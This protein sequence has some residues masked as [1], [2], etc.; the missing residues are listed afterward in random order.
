[1]PNHPRWT[2][3]VGL[4]SYSVHP[5]NSVEITTTITPK[6]QRKN[7]ETP[8]CS[9]NLSQQSRQGVGCEATAEVG[10]MTFRREEE[11]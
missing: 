1:M 11:T 8:T 7:E 5:S 6:H 4:G 3:L 10:Y 9:A 2:G